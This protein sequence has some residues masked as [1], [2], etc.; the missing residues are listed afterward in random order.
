[1][2]IATL[3]SV[4]FTLA[5]AIPK[6]MELIEQVQTLRINYILEKLDKE[7]SAK[8]VETKALVSAV[9]GAKNDEERMALSRLLFRHQRSSK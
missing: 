2:N 8:V 4:L 5:K 7:H 3:A 9:S 1:M 6:I